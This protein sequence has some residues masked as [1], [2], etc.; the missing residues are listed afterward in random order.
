MGGWLLN[1]RLLKVV[2]PG[3]VWTMTLGKTGSLRAQPRWV[4]LLGSQLLVEHVS[5]VIL[6]HVS[7]AAERGPRD[8]HPS[9]CSQ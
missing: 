9:P 5:R 8:A 2:F 6:T 7:I 1:G 3:T 4:P